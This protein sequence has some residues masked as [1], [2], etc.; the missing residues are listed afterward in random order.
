MISPSLC[1]FLRAF[2]RRARRPLFGIILLWSFADLTHRLPLQ[3][4]EAHQGGIHS[5]PVILSAHKHY[6]F[7]GFPLPTYRLIKNQGGHA[8]I[9]PFQIDEKNLYE[10]FVMDH[11][12][13]EEEKE[14]PAQGNGLFDG[15]D[16]LSFMGDD[17]GLK[18]LPQHWGFTKPDYLFRV[19]A[20]PGS[21][22]AQSGAVFV[23]IYLDPSTRPALSTKRYVHFDLKNSAI[24]TSRYHYSFD[25]K[26]YLAIR[27]LDLI[28]SQGV[29]K[30]VVETSSFFLKADLKYFLTVR[31]GHRD[32]TS[33]IKAY[34]NGPIRTM[35]KV[36]FLYK[37]LRLNFEMG[38]Y[39]E[40]SFFS[41]MVTL[42]TIMHNPLEGRKNLNRGSGF[43]YG[44][45]MPYDLALLDVQ[46]NMRPY[47]TSRS[48]LRP[49]PPVASLYH[50][51]LGDGEFLMQLSIKPSKQMKKSGP[52]LQ[53]YLEKGDPQAILKRD[54]L[55]PLPLGEAPVNL[56]AYLE[57]SNFSEG[58]HIIDFNLIFENN[59]SEAMKSSL[60]SLSH[61]IY[62]SSVVPRK[63][64][65]PQ[66]QAP[67]SEKGK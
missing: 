15:A 32:I 1:A 65:A 67:T 6:A 35:I 42:P 59:V 31:V 51:S 10:D 5:T 20:F 23:G 45:A 53:Y 30:R 58:E 57:L 27:K 48:L 64:W 8:R 4:T 29:P 24:K 38:M 21:K 39:T 18:D 19:D 16:E 43:Y 25:P 54:P 33:E 56:G 13:T 52:A 34:K 47:K 22:E 17:S 62:R 61:W 55:R 12:L 7:S 3:A 63:L 40:V 36:S 11:H 50:L 60:R 26:S 14:H 46:T 37:F 66:P 9:I 44:F 2:L 28:T 49:S 41:N